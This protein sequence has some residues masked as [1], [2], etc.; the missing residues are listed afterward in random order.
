MSTVVMNV[1]RLSLGHVR[2]HTVDLH[3]HQRIY[4]GA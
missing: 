4:D 2:R 3:S 1:L